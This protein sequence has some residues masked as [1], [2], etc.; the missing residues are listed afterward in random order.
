VMS[1]LARWT[2]MAGEPSRRQ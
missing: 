1:V 2:C